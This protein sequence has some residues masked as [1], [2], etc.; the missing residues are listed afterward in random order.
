MVHTRLLMNRTTLRSSGKTEP[1]KA[2]PAFRDRLT[3]QLRTQAGF[4]I[5]QD[6]FQQHRLV[7]GFFQHVRAGSVR[8]A[9]FPICSTRD[10]TAKP[11]AHTRDGKHKFLVDLDQ[12]F[13]R[14]RLPATVT[15]PR[16]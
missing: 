7:T 6:R 9:K 15:L 4:H 10:T 14:P 8:S 5:D 3:S 1:H 13:P 11:L 16:L 2:R 12:Q